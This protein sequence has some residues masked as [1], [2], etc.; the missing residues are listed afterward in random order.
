MYCRTYLGRVFVRKPFVLALI[1]KIPPGDPESTPPPIHTHTLFHKCCE[2]L[3]DFAISNMVN[4]YWIPDHTV[5]QN[6]ELAD[7]LARKSSITS[8]TG[9]EPALGTVSGSIKNY[10]LLLR[11]CLER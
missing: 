2:V 4:H 3:H 8:I 11:V 9:H 10:S 5:I 1:V 6:N 7:E